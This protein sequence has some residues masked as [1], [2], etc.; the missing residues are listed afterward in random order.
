VALVAGQAYFIEAIMKEG[1]GGDN[2]AVG[3]TGPGYASMTV[4]PG[5][6]L[7]PL[8]T[9]PEIAVDRSGNNVADG[10]TSS[11][12][13]TVP[14]V[15]TTINYRIQNTG[16]A[17]LTLGSFA[18]S[19]ASNCSAAVLTQP[20]SSIAAG[21]SATLAVRVTPSANGDWSFAVAGTTNDSDE[22]PFNFTVSGNANTTNPILP[23]PVAVLANGSFEAPDVGGASSTSFAYAPANSGWTF[24]GAGI[25]GNRSAFTN[26]NPTA[27]DGKQVA[28]LQNSGS[29]TQSSTF[30]AGTYVISWLAAN[31]GNQSQTIQLLI[32]NKPIVI[33]RPTGPEFEPFHAPSISLTAGPHTIQFKGLN[34]LGTDN[35]AFIDRVIIRK[36][37]GINDGGFESPTLAANAFIY[38]PATS[39]WAFIQGS[40]IMSNAS[41]FGNP[42]APSGSQAAFL[43]QTGVIRQSFVTG[44]GPVRITGMAAQRSYNSSFQIFDVRI[45]GQSIGSIRPKN[46]AFAPFTT[47]A[48]HLAPGLHTL[49]LVGLNPNGGDNT[50]FVDQIGISEGWPSNGSFESPQLLT[51][52]LQYRPA[53]AGWTFTGNAGVS[54]NGSAFGHTL[55]P[56]FSQVGFIQST[57]SISQTA[58][59]P[60]GAYVLAWR[61]SQRGLNSASQ[62]IS[63]R[64]DGQLITLCTPLSTQ[65]Q[66]FAEATYLTEG[67]HLISFTGTSLTD[68]TAFIDE[69]SLRPASFNDRS[70]E[71]PTLASSSWAT[72]PIGSSWTFTGGSGLA[73]SGSAYAPPPMTQGQ[74]AAFI[75]QWGAMHH[76]V[77]VPAGTYRLAGIASQRWSNQSAQT[78]AIQVDNSTVTTITP[79]GSAFTPFQSPTFNLPSGT[80]VIKLLGLNPNGGDN[81]LFLETLHLEMLPPTLPMATEDLPI[82]NG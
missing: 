47:P 38:R 55:A 48:L 72:N 17:P 28:F 14:G 19:G 34:P 20:G 49:E 35:T 5:S 8:P 10:G 44:D 2:L 46:T 78:I 22:N 61:A 51:N 76:T 41:P 4:I 13:G 1:T 27:P 11:I 37:A 12:T 62:S 43:Q 9:V 54:S 53:S 42:N 80:S 60:S 39:A 21:A 24:V 65:F 3:W 52:S 67:P 69:I 70:F 71:N 81:T 56:G 73:S 58:T 66:S 79:T 33:A 15:Q 30:E 25:S 26:A 57:G 31:R 36:V 6:V 32:D 29:I 59:T 68:N 50:A 16:N 7:A 64:V 40:G 75:Q 18:T 74:Q 45:D 82:G 77:K 63:V 23:S